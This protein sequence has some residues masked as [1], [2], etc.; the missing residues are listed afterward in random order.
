MNE[1]LIRPSLVECESE[2]SR[3]GFL[4]TLVR[5]AG[6]AAA[7]DNFGPKLFADNSSLA[8]PYQVF[9]ALG[10]LV[11][12]ID[13]D[14][15]WETFEPGITTFGVDVFIRNVLLNGNYLAFL[16]FLNCLNALNNAPVDAVYGPKFLDMLV[17][18]QLQYFSD[19][20]T[21][22]FE[23]D[24][25]GDLLGFAGGLSLI[26]TKGTF[27]SNY[28][29]HLPLVDD[30]GQNLEF[31]VRPLHQ[32]RTGWDIMQLK[33]PVGPDEEKALRAR[34]TGIK[35]IPGVDFDNNPYI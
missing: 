31:Q 3:R 6:I 23:N 11:I 9:G 27:F 22:R 33:G 16:G 26:A 30:H 13:Q 24:G 20:L 35:E 8:L 25:V 28:P 34:Y 21:G 12:P 17:G 19:I 32:I 18:Q 5:G 2:F 15:G 10:R 4:R 7:F 14:A 1:S 29:L